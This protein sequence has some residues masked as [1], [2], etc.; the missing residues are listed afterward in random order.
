MTKQSKSGEDKT[1]HTERQLND[2]LGQ[3]FLTADDKHAW[4]GQDIEVKSDPL[5]DNENSGALIL[6]SFYYKA[7][8]VTMKEQKPTKQKIFNSHLKQIEAMLWG[9]G[10]TPFT[11]I[12]P[13]I[14]VSKKRDE[15]KIFIA[16]VPKKGVMLNETPLTLQQITKQ[17]AT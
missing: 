11:P 13:R 10:L 4:E 5:I 3:K 9:D 12:E 15:Y 1:H 14:I 16:C 8:P 6:R 7:N 17:N 2:H